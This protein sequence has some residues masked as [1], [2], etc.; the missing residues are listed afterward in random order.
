MTEATTREPMTLS[1]AQR[2]IA[3]KLSEIPDEQLASRAG[4]H[5]WALDELETGVPLPR[6]LSAIPQH[7]G[8]YQLQDECSRCRKTRIVTTLP[9]GVYD[10]NAEYTYHNPDD[11]VTLHQDLDATKRVLRAENVA[12]N[13]GR[14]F[15]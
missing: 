14:L 1:P 9:K 5:R 10:I 6:G 12:R 4:R 7:D 8:S 15:R 13:A 11:W 3:V 2:R